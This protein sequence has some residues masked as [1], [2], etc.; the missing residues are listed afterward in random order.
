MGREWVVV[1][2]DFVNNNITT[3]GKF[4]TGKVRYNVHG[5]GRGGSLTLVCY[6]GSYSTTTICARGL[7]YKTPVAI[8]H[9]GVDSNGTHTVIY[10]DNVTG[11][12]GTSKIRGTRRVYGVATSTL[13]VS[14]DSVIM[15]SAK[16]VNRPVSLRPVGGNVTGLISNLGGSNSSSTTGTVVAASAMGGRF[17]YRFSLNNGGYHVNTVSGNDNVVRPGVTAV[18][19]F[20]AASTSVSTRVLGG[21]LLRIIGSDF[22][23]LS[24]SNSASAGSAITILTS[25]LYKGRGV[26]SRGTSCGT[27]AYTLTTVYRGLMGLVTGSN[28]NTAGLIRYVISNT[29][30]REATGVY[31]GSIV[32]SSLIGTTVF[33]TSTG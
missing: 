13:N 18:L 12:Y 31:T 29:T 25:K 22:G 33:K 26:A 19:T 21:S 20:V 27:F 32:Y 24:M 4:A 14:G 17:T 9:R 10:G 30:S 28:R 3:P 5:G 11:A 1:R 7:I 15:T 6:R 8:A 16:I 2:L 23:V